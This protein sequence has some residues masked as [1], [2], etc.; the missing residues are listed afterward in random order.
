MSGSASTP[1]INLNVDEDKKSDVFKHVYLKVKGQVH[2]SLSFISINFMFWIF[3]W[4][5]FVTL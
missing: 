5:I 2:F 1:T 3:Y 4:C